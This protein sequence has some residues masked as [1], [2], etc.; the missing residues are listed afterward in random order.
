MNKLQKLKKLIIKNNIDAYLVSRNDIFFNEFSKVENNQL[1]Y[2]TGFTGSAGIA[3]IS[4]D[5]NYL[6]VDGR[7]QEQAQ[8]ESGS[9]YQI[10]DHNIKNIV[11]FFKGKIGY[12]PKL[13]KFLEIEKLKKEKKQLIAINV[14]LI[15]EIKNNTKKVDNKKA[16]F[17]KNKYSGQQFLEKIRIVK[18]KLNINKKKFFLIS[19]NENLCWLINIRG[20]DLDY[21]PILNAWAIMGPDKTIVFCDKKKITNSIKKIYKKNVQ[22]EDLKDLKKNLLK[23]RNRQILI[24]K[25]TISQDIINFLR[26]QKI[27]LS[28][29]NDPIFFLKSKKNIIEI[30]NSKIAHLFDGVALTKLMAWLKTNSKKNLDEIKIQSKL[31]KI[32]HR[33]KYY[34]G[35]SFPTIAGF[36]KN[37]SIIHY[38]ANKNTNLKVKNGIFLIDSGGQYKFGTTDVT[39][40]IAIGKQNSIKKDIYTRVLKGHLAVSNFNLKQNT[41]GQEIDRK[42]RKFLKEKNFDYPHSTGH[43]VGYFLNVHETPPSISIK[44][45]KKFYEGQI[46]SNEPGFYRKGKFGFRVENLIYVERNKKKLRFSNLTMSPYDKN[47]ISRKILTKKELLQINLYHS[48]VYENLRFFLNKEELKFLINA[49]SPI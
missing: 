24:D 29:M 18:K 36:Q 23:L 31:E 43:G 21:S 39:R 15:N 10:I 3:L 9:N 8:K 42:A 16:Y 11:K 1:Q 5:K 13:F 2:M 37:A 19:S 33:N 20:K 17:L 41:K 14:N 7:Y 22:F 30:S 12:D 44:S 46:I 34:I 4:L 49:C 35:Q 28:L 6:F 38:N 40:T 26:S 32:R 48:I 45:K 27:K 25:I 47:L